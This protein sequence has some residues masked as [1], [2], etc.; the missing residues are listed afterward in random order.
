MNERSRE[1]AVPTKGER[2]RLTVLFSDL[3]GSTALGREM[4]LE[5]F[6]ELLGELR[7][8]WHRARSSTAVS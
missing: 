4:E 2:H 6:S 3:V 1:T 8:I 5:H 7:D